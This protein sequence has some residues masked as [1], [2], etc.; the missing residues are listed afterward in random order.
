MDPA[1]YLLEIFRHARQPHNNVRNLLPQYMPFGRQRGL[2]RAQLE[3]QRYKPL[4][5][6]VVQIA[7]E[8]A[9]GG[10]RSGY[11]PGP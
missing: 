10:V 1:R 5:G 2:G 8:S 9:P 3:P 11:D 6:T 4:L 7:F